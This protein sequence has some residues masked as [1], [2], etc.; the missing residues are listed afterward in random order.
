VL[1]VGK[2]LLVIAAVG[3]LLVG[4]RLVR[5]MNRKNADPV[6]TK[7]DVDAMATDL[8]KCQKCGAYTALHCGKQGCPVG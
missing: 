6:E 3:A 2:I 7:P 1:S 8:V 4:T 5:Q